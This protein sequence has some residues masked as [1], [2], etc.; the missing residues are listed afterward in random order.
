LDGTL[1]ILL[2]LVVGLPVLLLALLYPIV[3]LSLVILV[4]P[5]DNLI[6]LPMG[7]T[8]GR[9]LGVVVALAWLFKFLLTRRS[10]L[11]FAKSFNLFALLLI[12]EM[13]VSSLLSAFPGKS[14]GMTLTVI[15]LILMF[16]FVQDFV[17][18]ER[19][20]RALLA[21]IA[22]SIGA[23]SLVGILQFLGFE[24]AKAVI[25][26]ISSYDTGSDSGARFSGFQT[27]PN[28]YGLLMMAG[29]PFLFFFAIN[30]KTYFYRV[31]A[32]IVL[33]TSVVS[34]FLSLSRTQVAGFIVFGASVAFMNFRNG[35][36]SRKQM[37]YLGLLMLFFLVLYSQMPDFVGDRLVRYTFSGQDTSTEE[38][39]YILLKG[40]ELLQNNPFFGIGFGAF[41]ETDSKYARH[42]VPGV[43]GHDLVSVFFASTG[44][45]G[46]LLFIFLCYKTF[47]YL[48]GAQTSFRASNNTYLF[49]LTLT[50]KAAF[51]AVVS[52]SLGQPIVVER[53]FWVY[54]ALAAL[55]YRWGS[56]TQMKAAKTAAAGNVWPISAVT[57]SGTSFYSGERH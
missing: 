52:T 2:C 5:F 39:K 30:G 43:V 1:V 45:L 8:I 31:L 33:A 13:L 46:A 23:A 55:L 41:P 56:L 19:H 10:S 16:F 36:I 15:F 50:I 4:N 38:R 34:L 25:G 53:I 24:G 22:V 47:K 49:N 3:G 28:G 37:F 32:S 40:I 26:N 20:L 27:N 48:N 54:L 18:N 14:M 57:A 17:L 9:A 21:V 42:L 29:I 11:F 44:L 6:H 7:F 51:I 12:I 35:R